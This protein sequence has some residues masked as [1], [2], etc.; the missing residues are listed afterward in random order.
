MAVLCAG[1]VAGPAEAALAPGSG[2]STSA[3][4]AGGSGTGAGTVHKAA[5]RARHKRRSARP[6]KHKRSAC[7]RKK[8]CKGKKKK[9]PPP[10]PEPPP[11]GGG[12]GGSGG[13]GGGGEPPEATPGPPSST[14]PL[15]LFS[16]T[17]F[18]N[19]QL[20]ASA[21]LAPNSAQIVGAFMHQL[22]ANQGKVVIN[23]TQWSTPV[24][25]VGPSAPTVAMVGQSSICPRPEGVFSGFQA[26]IEA[27][28]IPANALPAAGSDKEVVIWQP[29]TKQ[30]W[31]LWRV[32]KEN[33]RWSACW[34]GRI[35]DATASS[36]SFEAPYGAAA[37]GLSLLGGQ[38]HLEDLEHGHV[39]HALELLLPHTA[40]GEF[41]WPAD[42]TDGAAKGGDAIAEG[43]RLRLP[44]SLDL[45]TLHLS[46][47]GLAIATA[48][49]R[50]GM[51]VAD[52][53]G[54][55]ALSA[56]DPSPL[57]AEGHANPYDTVLPNP[58][59]TLDS[60]PWEKLEVL[61]PSYHG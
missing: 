8:H 58:Y 59:D 21:P 46:P 18:Y 4:Q 17:S 3:D 51:I 40:A 44:S 43:T 27:V 10:S 13:G 57:I 23:T 50:Y 28:P 12:G 33:G 1:I 9:T 7:V 35:A 47:S 36:G 55:V 38:I 16:A 34:G 48:I 29:S 39:N 31:E 41:V 42:R 52:T 61:S 20:P 37:S 25:T 26:Q 15:R 49:Q 24:Y 56:Q 53:A 45:S 14:E 11:P 30:L 22:A 2:A 60:V 19:A 6:H 32:A 54:S 5:R